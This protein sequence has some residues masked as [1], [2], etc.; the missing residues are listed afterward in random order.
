[1]RK[2]TTKQSKQKMS[3][4]I[5]SKTLLKQMMTSFYEEWCEIEN[6]EI[7]TGEMALALAEFAMDDVSSDELLSLLEKHDFD[8]IFEATLKL[9][10]G[11]L[12]DGC[13]YEAE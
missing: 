10:I 12:K 8:D 4:V 2:L 9:A 3:K 6:T 5:F 1:M 13:N 11:Y 7:T